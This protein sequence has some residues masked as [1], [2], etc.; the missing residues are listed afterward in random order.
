M[1]RKNGWQIDFFSRQELNR[2]AGITPSAVVYQAIGAQGV[3]E[4][5]ALLSAAAET[6]LMEKQKWP[7]V[8]LALARA[9]F[10]LS[11]RVPAACNT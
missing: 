9:N 4:P 3:A 8:T 5:A 2:V 11:A 10:T 1:A 6:L 7:N